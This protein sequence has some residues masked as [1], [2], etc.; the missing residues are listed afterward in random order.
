MSRVDVGLSEIRIRRPEG[1]VYALLACAFN[2][3]CARHT[4]NTWYWKLSVFDQR[5]G[6]E[7]AL[8]S[9][10]LIGSLAMKTLLGVRK[11]YAKAIP[12]FPKHII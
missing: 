8:K 12:K 3:I 11:N 2:S 6:Y 9:A 10:F 5:F 7:N 1:L 4:R